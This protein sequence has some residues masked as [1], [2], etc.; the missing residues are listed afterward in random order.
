M[1][2]LVAIDMDGTLLDS[3]HQLSIGNKEALQ[4]LEEKDV[5]VVLCTGRPLSGVIPYFKELDLHHD[6][7]AILNN[8]CSTFHTASWDLMS[9]YDIKRDSLEELLNLTKNFPEIY[10]TLTTS[11]HYYV[12]GDTVP[13]IVQDDADLVFDIVQPISL[14]DFNTNPEPIFKVMYVGEK[15]EMDVFESY[16]FEKLSHLFNTVRSQ[17]YL[18]EI[19]PKGVSKATGLKDLADKLGIK[20][21]QIMAIGDQLNDLEMLNYVGLGVAMGNAPEKVKEAANVITDSNDNDGVAKV[22]YQ[23]CVM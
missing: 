17:D 14:S 6:N 3:K 22:I 9:Y 13:K 15:G 23:Y 7:Y 19:L 12:I 1:I 8:G 4:A 21:E 16:V 2:K 18:F 20:S 11:N 5:Q 10:M